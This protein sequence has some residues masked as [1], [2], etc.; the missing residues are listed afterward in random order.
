MTQKIQLVNKSG[1]HLFKE[2]NLIEHEV[3]GVK[4]ISYQEVVRL[5]SWVKN[6][7]KSYNLQ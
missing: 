4:H 3:N 1:V 5:I 7:L 6:I 2:I